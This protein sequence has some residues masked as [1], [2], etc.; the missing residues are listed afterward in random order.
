[1]IRKA[2]IVTRCGCV[3]LRDLPASLAHPPREIRAALAVGTM[4]S[5]LLTADTPLRDPGDQTP[6]FRTFEYHE[7]L[8]M[9]DPDTGKLIRVAEYHEADVWPGCP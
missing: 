5:V 1:M 7:T 8:E 3:D 2:L 9:D 4:G 6:R